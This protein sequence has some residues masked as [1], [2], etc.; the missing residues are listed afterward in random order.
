MNVETQA[1]RSKPWLSTISHSYIRQFNI[2]RAFSAK[3]HCN[4]FAGKAVAKPGCCWI[5]CV[6]SL[7]QAA[8][9]LSLC[10]VW[11]LCCGAGR[12]GLAGCHCHGAA[13]QLLHAWLSLSRPLGSSCRHRLALSLLG[14]Q[15]DIHWSLH[16]WR[17]CRRHQLDRKAWSQIRADDCQ[18]GSTSWKG[19]AQ[20]AALGWCPPAPSPG[21]TAQFSRAVRV[22][23]VLS[24]GSPPSGQ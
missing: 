24:A 5:S 22:K 19:K 20:T 3:P 11:H 16:P 13:K 12:A 10:Q 9:L 6:L 15:P 18:G 17:H 2:L 23:K 21:C 8:L 4:C 14:L 7:C 1:V